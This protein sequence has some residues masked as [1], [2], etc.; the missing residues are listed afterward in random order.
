VAILQK[1]SILRTIQLKQITSHWL[2]AVDTAIQIRWADPPPARRLPARVAQ[3]PHLSRHTTTAS[4]SDIPTMTLIYVT[5]NGS[6]VLS[7]R[8]HMQIISSREKQSVTSCDSA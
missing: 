8:W 7:S 1:S 3:R 6:G 2:E 4:W 5:V